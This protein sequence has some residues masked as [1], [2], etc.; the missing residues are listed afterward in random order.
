M[1]FQIFWNHAGYTCKSSRANSRL[2]F[3]YVT[4]L[5]WLR[6]GKLQEVPPKNGYFQINF[7]VLARGIFLIFF[8]TVTRFGSMKDMYILKKLKVIGS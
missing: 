6:Q 8:D 5:D 7:I 3:E 2:K 4:A 1:C